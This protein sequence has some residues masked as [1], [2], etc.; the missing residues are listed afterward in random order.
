MVE[1]TPSFTLNKRLIGIY[2]YSR[3][4]AF[5]LG[6]IRFVVYVLCGVYISF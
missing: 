3:T 6:N 4:K 5:R 1:R 2:Q